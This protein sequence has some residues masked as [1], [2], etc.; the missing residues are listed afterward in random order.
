MRDSFCG[1]MARP[2]AGRGWVPAILTLGDWKPYWICRGTANSDREV[3]FGAAQ[4]P[5]AV[6]FYSHGGRWSQIT[7]AS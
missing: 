6:F 2:S 5:R 3:I 1:A 7:K 4:I